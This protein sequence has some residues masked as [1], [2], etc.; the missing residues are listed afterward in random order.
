MIKVSERQLGWILVRVSQ[1]VG[2]MGL[3]GKIDSLYRFDQPWSKGR[4]DSMGWMAWICSYVI[5]LAVTVFIVVYIS[6]SI[7]GKQF[8]PFAKVSSNTNHL[9]FRRHQWIQRMQTLREHSRGEIITALCEPAFSYG[10]IEDRSQKIVGA[11]TLPMII[12]HNQ[13]WC[14]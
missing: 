3:R 11:E 7:W 10:W 13:G 9:P 12:I 6:F 8:Q 4:A 14:S 2:R 1:I 5:L